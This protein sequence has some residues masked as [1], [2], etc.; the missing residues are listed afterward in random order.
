MMHD[1]DLQQL[2][3]EEIEHVAGGTWQTWLTALKNLSDAKAEIAKE[4]ARNS[5]G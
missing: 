4:I 3:A 5:R 2:T 1:T